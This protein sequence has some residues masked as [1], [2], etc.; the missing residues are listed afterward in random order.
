MTVPPLSNGG[1]TRSTIPLGSHKTPTDRNGNAARERR[2]AGPTRFIGIDG[3][4]V[5]ED[6]G[7]HRYVLL[8]CGEHHLH[9]DGA[10]LGFTDIAE[11]LWACFTARSDHAFVGFYLGYDWS[12]WVRDL[13][14]DRAKY[15]VDTQLIAGR[16]R[17][18][19][20]HAPPFPVL[21]SGWE[22]DWLYGRRF[23]L[24]P[25]GDPPRGTPNSLI[26]KVRI[27]GKVIRRWKWLTVCDVGSFFQCSFMKAIDPAANL[28]PIVTDAEYRIIAKGKAGRAAA[29][30]DP[31]MITYNQ[32]ECDVLVRLM[33]QQDEGIRSLVGKLNRGQWI[34]PGQVAQKWLA[35]IEAPDAD[36]VQDSIPPD[37]R[38]AAQ[39]AY[40]GGWFEI[41][42]HG[43]IKG[44]VYG[45]DINSAYPKVMED[46][47]DIRMFHWTHHGTLVGPI[48]DGELI[49]VRA[50]VEGKHPVVGAMMHRTPKG[51]V[52]RPRKT[53]GWY[54]WHEIE[55]ARDA[56][57]IFRC[58]IRE[59]WRGVTRSR[60][61][62]LAAIRGLYEDRL[63][64]GKNTPVGKAAKL[65]YNSCYGK[66][67]QSIGTPRFG[68]AIYA[69]LIT[70]GCRTMILRAIA[71]HPKGAHDLLMIATDGIVFR[72]RHPGLPLSNRLGE[73]EE[74]EHDNLS[75]FMPGV[76]WDDR[77]RERLRSGSDPGLKSRGISGRDLGNRLAIV[78]RAWPRFDRDGWPRLVIPVEFSLVSP[79]QAA[80]RGKWELCGTVIKDAQRVIN[81]DPK[82]KRYATRP[83]RSRPYEQSDPLIS[84]PYNGSFGDDYRA[85]EDD[86]F[87]DNPDGEISDLIAEELFGR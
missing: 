2:R 82:L 54:W 33:E 48:V 77:T 62:P 51:A 81:A 4:G 26:H 39:G 43:P 44:K 86:E 74:T 57:F 73:W 70:A 76:Y 56:G 68:N 7:T 23:K 38:K 14:W 75:L 27:E 50:L 72:S 22:F 84:T 71:S 11:F 61:R 10:T 36:S 65:V 42:W 16:A 47:P 78:D 25:E 58:D 40:Y 21:Y 6:D 79:R 17:H 30:F 49:L 53:E 18:F 67:A 69:S 24:R 9:L 64:L 45:Y 37:V 28:R 31:A 34:G 32:L 80:Q 1:H 63:K 52:L 55:A 46:L 3:E 29:K 85:L 15:L 20:P 59:C 12:Q 19:I 83:G 13:P 8:S 66:F 60:R 35:Q 5:T 41:F 87:G